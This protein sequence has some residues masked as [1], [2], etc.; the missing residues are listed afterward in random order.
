M[1]Q[2][3]ALELK[4]SRAHAALWKCHTNGGDYSA[5]EEESAGKVPAA[6]EFCVIVLWVETSFNG[7]CNLLQRHKE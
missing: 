1:K 3:N 7:I 5:R 6:A 2:A 4:G